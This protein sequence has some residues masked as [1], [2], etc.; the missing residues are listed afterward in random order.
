M[1]D[2]NDT[3]EKLAKE[4]DDYA[5]N[6]RLKPSENIRVLDWWVAAD[7]PNLRPL[8]TKYL[9]SPPSSA[10][11]ERMFSGAGQLYDERRNRLT[12]DHAE[13]ILFLMFWLKHPKRATLISLV[14]KKDR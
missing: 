8:V 11:S 13:K 4:F 3:K 10:A 1:P 14:K 12:A 5:K 2:P 6:R 7:Y 9:C